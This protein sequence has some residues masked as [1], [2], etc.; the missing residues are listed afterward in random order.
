MAALMYY[1]VVMAGT[2]FIGRNILYKGTSYVIDYVLNTNADPDIKD[3]HTVETIRGMLDTYKKISKNHPAYESLQ[4]VATALKELQDEVDRA[5]LRLS[6]HENGWVTR[7]RTYD[8]RSDNTRIE[9]KSKELM[10]RLDIFTKLIKLSV[11]H[12]KKDEYSNKEDYGAEHTDTLTNKQD[13]L[14]VTPMLTLADIQV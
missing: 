2:Y 4:S 7:F 6:V 9:K 3:T 12:D 10:S 8:A 14:P 13:V 5:R 1:P 11:P